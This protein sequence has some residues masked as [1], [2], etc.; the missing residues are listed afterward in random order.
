MKVFTQS[1]ADAARAAGY[2]PVFADEAAA[3]AA[4]PRARSPSTTD[5]ADRERRRYFAFI[6]MSTA[7]RAFEGGVV[8]SMMPQIAA[9]LG[10][11][12]AREGIIAGSP[13]FGIVPAGRSV[14]AR[15]P[16]GGIRFAFDGSSSSS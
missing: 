2:D 4:P 11:D 5:A 14:R 10:I 7:F 15:S 13:D 8:A 3:A 6:C 9:E 16:R 12:Y 1:E